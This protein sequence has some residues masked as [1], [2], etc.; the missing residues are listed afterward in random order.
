MVAAAM[1]DTVCVNT[2]M[3]GVIRGVLLMNIAAE[4]MVLHCEDSTS[5]EG[6][7]VEIIQ[8]H[9]RMSVAPIHCKT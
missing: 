5:E 2:A 6:V 8:I 1:N 4:S 9:H 3:H 7:R